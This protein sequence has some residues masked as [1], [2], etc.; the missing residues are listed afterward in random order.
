MHILV[1]KILPFSLQSWLKKKKNSLTRLYSYLFFFS[2]FFLWE[3]C[4]EETT[5][6]GL[7]KEVVTAVQVLK[8]GMKTYIRDCP[9]ITRSNQLW[10]VDPQKQKK[11][12]F[13]CRNQTL[14]KTVQKHIFDERQ[15][16][17]WGDIR[18][19]WRSLRSLY[20]KNLQNQTYGQGSRF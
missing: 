17:F 9:V 4:P 10:I 20:R 8:C 7:W 16:F 18:L 3:L 5:L 11:S 13:L 15:V 19:D 14:L 6:T 1:L 2:F 12:E